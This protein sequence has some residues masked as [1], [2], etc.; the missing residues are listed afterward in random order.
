M[1]YCVIVVLLLAFITAVCSHE[2][3]SINQ[4]F[5]ENLMQ[6]NLTK[7]DISNI[8]YK[9][10]IFSSKYFCRTHFLCVIFQVDDSGNV[11]FKSSNEEI[12]PEI[13][14]G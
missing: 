11:D 14:I 6:R 9:G 5:P 12:Y 13:L 4:L 3:S 10:T 8:V 7:N 1:V 2:V